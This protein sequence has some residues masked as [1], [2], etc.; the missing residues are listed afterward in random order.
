MQLR[1]GMLSAGDHFV[2]GAGVGEVSRGSCWPVMLSLAAFF[3]RLV[4][5]HL[6]S[7]P[8]AGEMLAGQCP[9]LTSCWAH[10]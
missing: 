10:Q 9:P 7:T 3:S 1:W 5:R 6:L 2:G 4:S 8:L